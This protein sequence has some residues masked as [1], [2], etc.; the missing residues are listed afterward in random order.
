MKDIPMRTA[1]RLRSRV[2]CSTIPTTLVWL[3]AV[4]VC[5]VGHGQAIITTQ[6]QAVGGV[7]INTNGVLSNALPD[8]LGTLGKL[9]GQSL[10]KIPG[11]LNPAVEM[12]K[13]SL[14]RLDTAL[15]DC[16]KNN[17]PI[18]DALKYLAGLQR[19]RYVF[20]YPEQKDIVLV[21]P[22]EGWKVDAKGNMVGVTTGRP[23]M[24]LDDLL[25][26]LRTARAAANG[27]I[28]CSIDP[29]KE[30]LLRMS[31]QLPALTSSG[32][33]Q[34][35]AGGIESALG[36]Q[37]I[38]VHGVPETSH[39]ARVLVAADY[40][41][42]RIAMNF[43]PSPVR[44]L[45]SYLQMVKPSARTVLSP[46]FWLEPKYEAL[47]RDGEGLAFE[48]RGSG[49][50]ALTEED[51]VAASGN[52]QHSGKAGPA[53]Q[54][55]ADLMTEKYPELAVADP[56]FGQLQNCMELAV[57]G[58]LVVKEQL[59][60]KAGGSMPTLLDSSAVKPEAF[61]SPKQVESKASVLKKGRN[62]V[63]SASGG[64]AINSWI[65]ADQVRPSDAVAPVRAKAAAAETTNWY[66]N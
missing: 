9:R 6:Q 60:E 56:I 10:E 23:V 16:A 32:D 49:V 66:W 3:V 19:V 58:A 50:K 13:V 45:P 5:N 59:A 53:A 36:M 65:I 31:Q 47:L 25:V 51:F 48:L 2:L 11:D 55:W 1:N 63:I 33:P 38:S 41:M 14:R 7:S 28:T 52:I 29:T 8:D 39:F 24:L 46:R 44:G 12:R 15:E 30:G 42:K 35:V 34:T 4:A 62:W 17:K 40:R 64:V 61:H 22:G 20:V 57:V 54:K 21:G 43:D 27:G 26:A 37:Q 18:P